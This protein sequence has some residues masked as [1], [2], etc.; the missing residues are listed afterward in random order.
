MC[1]MCLGKKQTSLKIRHCYQEGTNLAQKPAVLR[2]TVTL[3]AA[4]T[5][6]TAQD[7]GG[8][9]VLDC[10]LLSFQGGKSTPKC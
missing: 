9:I 6:Y 10:F 2:G 4:C 1:W 7:S 3:K 5:V 8:E